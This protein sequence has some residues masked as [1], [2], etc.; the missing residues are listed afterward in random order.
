MIHHRAEHIYSNLARTLPRFPTTVAEQ[1][2]GAAVSVEPQ[3]QPVSAPLPPPAAPVMPPAPPVAAV[4]TAPQAVAPPSPPTVAEPQRPVQA[5]IA[6]ATDSTGLSYIEAIQAVKDGGNIRRFGWGEGISV[7]VED[8]VRIM[9]R[10]EKDHLPNKAIIDKFTPL[11]GD[12]LSKDWEVL[13]L[14]NCT[15][16]EAIA[17]L[18][19]GQYVRRASWGTRI[20]IKDGRFCVLDD[21]Q[22]EYTLRYEDVCTSDWEIMYKPTS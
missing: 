4:Q 7:F 22:Q 9:K 12:V 15:F 19:R 14:P 13:P 2:N 21:S 8:S 11:V 16:L 1:E 6:L 17:A 20:Q 10:T 3:P 5:P 18:E